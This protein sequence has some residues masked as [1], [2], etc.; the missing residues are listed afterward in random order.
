MALYIQNEQ[1]VQRLAH[2][3]AKW[4]SGVLE[5]HLPQKHQKNEKDFPCV[6]IYWRAHFWDQERGNWGTFEEH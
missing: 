2:G 6:I 3:L 4:G 1:K 5:F